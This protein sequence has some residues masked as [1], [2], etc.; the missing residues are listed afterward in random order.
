MT[1][2]RQRVVD[3][4]YREENLEYLNGK[5]KHESSHLS[6][7]KTKENRA[8]ALIIQELGEHGKDSNQIRQISQISK[9][10]AKGLGLGDV[11]CDC[12][13]QAAKLYD[14]GNIAISEEV[15]TKE[16]SLTD[17]EFEVVKD[18]TL[19]G[20]RFLL[21]FDFSTTQ[22]AANISI[23]HHEWW[24]GTG[25]PN[26]LK[27]K[28]I[29]TASRIVSLADTVGALFARRP[30]RESWEYVKILKYIE[31]RKGIQFDPVLVEVLMLNK[32]KIYHILCHKYGIYGK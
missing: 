25:Y 22:L 12:L 28:Q 11:Y 24:D 31:N 1:I 27:G 4:I 30:G 15:Y 2:H 18:H 17:E 9:I 16:K 3:N 32:A 10:L 26:Y 23:G 6:D 13:E 29:D 19:L 20:A 21:K 7:R 5:I 14:I 8:I